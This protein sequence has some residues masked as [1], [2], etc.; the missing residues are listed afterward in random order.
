MGSTQM[1]QS[2]REGKRAARERL[3]AERERERAR[4]RRRRQ[5]TVI[6]SVVGVIAVV[7]GIGAAVAASKSKSPSTKAPY[8]SPAGAVTD[9]AVANSGALAAIPYGD[10]NAP[11]TLSVYEDFR[12]PD[13][14]QFELQMGSVYKAYVTAGKVRV[15][16]H[17]VDLIDTMHPGTSG[18]DVA[19]SAAMCAQDEGKFEA[20]HDLLYQNQP[21][22]GTDTYSDVPTLLKLAKNVPGLD[23]PAFE[24]CVTA[25]KYK[26]LVAHNFAVL[27]NLDGGSAATPTLFIN[28][29][30]FNFSSSNTTLAQDVA[31]FQAALQA[32][33]AGP[34]PSTSPTTTTPTA[35]T[36][37]T[38]STTPT[39]TGK[40]TP[41][42]SHT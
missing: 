10:A 9:T 18:S 4:A 29:K 11:V 21:S 14:K 28:G 7:V 26:A 34:M 15:M 5:W 24:Q 25:V 22:E 37:P 40:P 39:A 2:N 3:A 35:S 31:Q 23:T 36:T 41:T 30:K 20:Y 32:A 1:S 17:P 38:S 27:S 33:G 16:Y 42:A 6:G 8:T 19:G 12:C 13:C